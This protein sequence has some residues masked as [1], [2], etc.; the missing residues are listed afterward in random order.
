MCI[1]GDGFCV[2]CQH[3]WQM[4]DSPKRHVY[5]MLESR[6]RILARIIIREHDHHVVQGAARQIPK[7]LDPR[8]TLLMFSSLLISVHCQSQ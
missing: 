6:L 5:R 4:L 8:V 3:L 1:A 7:R 2:S